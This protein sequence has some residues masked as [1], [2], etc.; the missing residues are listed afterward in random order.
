MGPPSSL[1][2]LPPSTPLLLYA[3]S[4]AREGGRWG[5]DE[6]DARRE[7]KAMVVF[8]AVR[9]ARKRLDEQ[10]DQSGREEE[11]PARLTLPPFRRNLFPI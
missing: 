6:K 3:A 10:A 11:D 8:G 4:A 9:I 2:D 1:N 5:R 7:R